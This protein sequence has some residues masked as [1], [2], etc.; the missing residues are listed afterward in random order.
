MASHVRAKEDAYILV[1]TDP[2]L[3]SLGLPRQLS[4]IRFGAAS[5]QRGRACHL[6]QAAG[7]NK[8]TGQQLLPLAADGHGYAEMG[9]PGDVHRGAQVDDVRD[10]GLTDDR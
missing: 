10:G 9:L 2:S 6:W 8:P 3:P 4:Y 1:A 7:A 5:R